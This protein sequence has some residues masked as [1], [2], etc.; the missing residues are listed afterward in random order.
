M[1]PSSDTAA[2]EPQSVSVLFFW[3]ML[4]A[5]QLADQGIGLYARNLKFL[6]EEVK[7]HSELRPKLATDNEVLLN[8][9]T[10]LFRNYSIPSAAGIPT[11][12]IAPY[13]GHSAMIADYHRGQSL[14]ETLRDN[15]V[16]RVFLTDWKSATDDMKDLEIDQYLAEL[17]VCVDDL[18]GRA[19]LIGLCQ[20][21]WMAAMLA[22]GSRKRSQA[23][24][25]P[26]LRSTPTPAMD[27]SNAWRT[28]TRTA[29]TKSWSRWAAA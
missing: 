3:P 11:I 5:A 16:G 19:N 10:M 12:V 2:R 22:R 8:L 6:A 18:G 15:G 17:T 27:R 1:S 14:M 24:C 9:R 29:F 26:A 21:G 7:I 23:S 4:A 28:L 25:L 13:A 20:G